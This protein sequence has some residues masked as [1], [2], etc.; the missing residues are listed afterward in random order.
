MTKLS[1][2]LPRVRGRSGR[3]P[4]RGLTTVPRVQ[5]LIALPFAS[6]MNT[7][8]RSGRAPPSARFADTS[9]VNGGG[10]QV[11]GPLEPTEAFLRKAPQDKGNGGKRSF[12][13][14]RPFSPPASSRT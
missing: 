12:T 4:G 14:S 10:H 11:G 7:P 13:L 8:D 3:R 6:L 9:P 2:V 1:D 5:R